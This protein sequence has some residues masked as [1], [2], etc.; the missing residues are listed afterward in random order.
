MCGRSRRAVPRAHLAIEQVGPAEPRLP[1]PGERALRYEWR[2]ELLH[3]RGEVSRVITYVDH[4][5]PVAAT[6]FAS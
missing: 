3:G 5:A 4:Y 2:G 6:F 1:E